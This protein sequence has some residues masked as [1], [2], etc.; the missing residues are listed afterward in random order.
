MFAKR[1]KP[2]A[3]RKKDVVVE[4]G[5]TDANEGEFG[6]TKIIGAPPELK[7]SKR[8]VES[9]GVGATNKKEK[10]NEEGAKDPALHAYSSTGSEVLG[11]DSRATATLETETSTDQDTRAKH[12]R[13]LQIHKDILEGKLEEGVY[14]G[15]D[16]Y[17]RIAN[18]SEGALQ[19]SKYSGLMG[20]TRGMLHVRVNC[21]FDY[22]PDVCKDYKE[23]GYCGWGDSCKFAHDRSDYKG[24]W[25]LEKEWEEQQKRKEAER[26]KKLERRMAGE[27]TDSENS[28]SDDDELPFACLSCR[29]KWKDCDSPPV[30]TLCSHYFCEDCALQEFA[31]SPKCAACNE[32]TNGIFNNAEKITEMLAKKKALEVGLAAGSSSSSAKKVVPGETWAGKEYGSVEEK[33][34]SS[35]VNNAYNVSL[36]D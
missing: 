11:Q 33:R 16:G 27:E 12:E 7:G 18:P 29:R 15:L 34:A 5:G 1:A 2:G 4:E 9:Q 28:D 6:E 10:T 14:R 3:G 8:K 19:N 17:K 35:R 23:T 32:P 31:Q 20:P 24:G 26:A 36:E 30:V 13:N 21:R 25:Q 22:M